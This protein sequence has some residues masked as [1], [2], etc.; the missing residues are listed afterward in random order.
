[1]HRLDII[2]AARLQKRTSRSFNPSIL[3][4]NIGLELSASNRT[5][6]AGNFFEYRRPVVNRQP[7]A[8][9]KLPLEPSLADVKQAVELPPGWRSEGSSTGLGGR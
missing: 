9:G 8:P 2:N 1:M 4:T 3:Q 7:F 6:R 5:R